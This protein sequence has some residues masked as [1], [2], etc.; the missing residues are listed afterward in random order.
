MGVLFWTGGGVLG[1]GG[2]DGWS[3]SVALPTGGSV[4]LEE[5]LWEGEVSGAAMVGGVGNNAHLTE[6]Q[7][8]ATKRFFNYYR[9]RTRPFEMN[10]LCKRQRGRVLG[11]LGSVT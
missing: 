3:S 2:G 1:C 8:D 4:A 7:P 9:V 6:L 11:Y 10:M 5:C